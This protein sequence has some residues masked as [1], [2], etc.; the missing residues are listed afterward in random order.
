MMS[1][2]DNVGVARKL[3]LKNPDWA[4]ETFCNRYILGIFTV[5]NSNLFEPAPRSRCDSQISGFPSMHASASL[6]PK[7]A[8]I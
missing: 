7:P 5:P 4:P 2:Q 3:P 6:N 8:A 1:G